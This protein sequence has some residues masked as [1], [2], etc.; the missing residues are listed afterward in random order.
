VVV[1][2]GHQ[3]S[4]PLDLV[5]RTFTGPNRFR[6]WHSCF[7]LLGGNDLHRGIAKNRGPAQDVF[8][9]ILHQWPPNK[10]SMKRFEV[11]A[12]FSA[13]AGRAWR[14]RA[15]GG[16]ALVGCMV[17]SC[18]LFA[19]RGFVTI[20][21]AQPADFADLQRRLWPEAETLGIK[22]DVFD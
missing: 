13:F 16:R 18:A 2:I 10:H 20:S 9:P 14:R 19:P 12:G 6:R 4:V 11:S 3:H 17:L 7:Y 5:P 8:S 22:R 1:P 15:Q 21:R